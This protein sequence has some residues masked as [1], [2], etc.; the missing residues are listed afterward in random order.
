MTC[1]R[2]VVGGRDSMGS[3]TEN[4]TRT[5]CSVCAHNLLLTL[6]PPLPSYMWLALSAWELGKEGTAL[7]AV[8]SYIQQTPAQAHYHP[9]GIVASPI[10]WQGKL[11]SL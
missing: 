10:L 5:I 6:D 7:L 9:L 8:V 11:I 1:K 3:N 2:Q 4:L